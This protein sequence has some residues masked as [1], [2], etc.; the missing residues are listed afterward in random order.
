MLPPPPDVQM[1]FAGQTL[2]S[3][4]IAVFQEAVAKLDCTEAK[5]S[6]ACT[7]SA[8]NRMLSHPAFWK[9]FQLPGFSS[10]EDETIPRAAAPAFSAHVLLLDPPTTQNEG[11]HGAFPL[12]DHPSAGRA[13]RLR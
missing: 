11:V 12:P 1:K 5:L 10:H 2:D 6:L 4:V 3:D 9:T 8:W 13:R 7:C